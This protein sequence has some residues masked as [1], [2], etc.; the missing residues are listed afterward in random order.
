[1]ILVPNFSKV[2]ELP[3]PIYSIKKSVD[4]Y[5]PMKIDYKEKVTPFEYICYDC[6]VTNCKLWRPCQTFNPRLLCID[7]LIIKQDLDINDV[8]EE[9]QY[10]E[11]ISSSYLDVIKWYVPAI[12]DVEGDGYWGYTSVPEVGVNWW[13]K[14][15]TRGQPDVN[16]FFLLKNP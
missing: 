13:R 8:N 5:R 6:G 7:C 15:P 3:K 2:G 10:F 9:G 14:L 11:K 12:P 16:K 1:M 4:D